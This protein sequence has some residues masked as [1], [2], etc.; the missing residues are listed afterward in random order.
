M[1]AFSEVYIVFL[2]KEKPYGGKKSPAQR[3]YKAKDFM[4]YYKENII[5]LEFVTYTD[6][7]VDVLR[8]TITIYIF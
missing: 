7:E 8:R 1:R 4:R 6:R 5:L 3:V 2:Y